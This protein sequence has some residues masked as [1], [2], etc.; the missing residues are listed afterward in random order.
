MAVF[1]Q[2][3]LNMQLYIKATFVTPLSTSMS[4][5]SP[6][7]F[8]IIFDAKTS[9]FTRRVSNAELLIALSAGE[10]TTVD[11]RWILYSGLVQKGLS[12]LTDSYHRSRERWSSRKRKS[13]DTLL[14]HAFHLP[15]SSSKNST[16]YG[17][18]SF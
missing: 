4:L 1:L 15:L 8:F 10:S 12:D 7:S 17:L 18:W 9:D 16:F 2:S 5:M 6:V 3:G 11:D 13:G 14:C